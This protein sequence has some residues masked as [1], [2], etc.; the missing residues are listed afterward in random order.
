MC[1]ILRLGIV[2]TP[3]IL[4]MLL[5]TRGRSLSVG[6][7]LLLSFVIT[8]TPHT[9]FVPG[10]WHTTEASSTSRI[11]GE[12]WLLFWSLRGTMTTEWRC[13]FIYVKEWYERLMHNAMSHIITKLQEYCMDFKGVRWIWHR[14]RAVLGP[15]GTRGGWS[16]QHAGG[17]LEEPP[18]AAHRTGQEVDSKREGDNSYSNMT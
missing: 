17:G 1:T 4:R 5:E 13:Y 9:T 18:L 7:S 2:S 15:R 12:I 10:S 11:W 6:E 8:V 14:T 16:R 3:L